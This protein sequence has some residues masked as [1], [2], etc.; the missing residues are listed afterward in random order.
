MYKKDSTESCP[1]SVGSVL[2]I[3][4]PPLMPIFLKQNSSEHSETKGDMQVAYMA[5]EDETYV[6]NDWFKVSEMTNQ[7]IIK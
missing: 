4:N 2:L 3:C 6:D 1:S 5:N 7:C